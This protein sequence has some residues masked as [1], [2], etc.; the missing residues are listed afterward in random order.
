MASPNQSVRMFRVGIFVAISLAAFA[1]SVFLIGRGRALFSKKVTLRAQFENT[2]GLVV[3]SPVRLA[4][5][6]IGIVE[7]I[8]FSPD[9]NIKTVEVELG[10][11]EAYLERIREDS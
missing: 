1:T 11:Q 6:D 5:V 2:G 3:G 9:R 7:K 8:R 10:V 4:G